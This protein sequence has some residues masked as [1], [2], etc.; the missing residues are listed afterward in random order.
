MSEETLSSSD[1]GGHAEDDPHRHIFRINTPDAPCGF[2]NY[3]MVKHYVIARSRTEATELAREFAVDRND[4]EARGF[5]AE[6]LLSEVIIDGD[7]DD[8]NY[9]L[10][11]SES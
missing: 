7:E 1:D 4:V 6:C 9:K 2:C 3:R 5:C 10:I 8:P 11:R